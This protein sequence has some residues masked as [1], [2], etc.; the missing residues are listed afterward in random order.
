M[1]RTPTALTA[2]AVVLLAGCADETIAPDAAPPNQPPVL[3][4]GVSAQTL[5]HGEQRK[6]DLTG[7]FH[8]PD[9]DTLAY[10]AA[11][12]D[13]SVVFAGLLPGPVVGI[14]GLAQG[15]AAVTVVARDPEGLEARAVLPVSV[16]ENPDRAALVALYEATGGPDW[17]HNDNWLTDAPLWQWSGVD[18]D[19]TGRV[20]RL[21]LGSNNLTG[22]IPL[23][24]GNLAALEWLDLSEN[25]A[26][27][28][29][30]PPELGNLT[31]LEWLYLSNGLTG[32]IPPELGRLAALRVLRLSENNALTGPI[33]PELGDL[34]ALEWLDLSRT[35]LTGPIPPELGNLSA[36]ENLNLI[37]TGL[38]GP[39]PPE[40]GNLA[41]LE[42]LRLRDNEG[43]SGP[44]P[45]ELGNLA[46]LQELWLSSNGLTGPIPPELGNL[47]TLEA[48]HLDGNGLT[49]PIPPELGNLAALRVLH[50]RDNE[51]LSGPLPAT[52]TALE[53]LGGLFIDGTGLCIPG[54]REFLD[55]Q[56][57]IGTFF[58]GAFCNEAD[59]PVLEELYAAAGG[60]DWTRSDGWLGSSP[61][62]ADWHGVTTDSLGRVA[63][64]SL[65]ANNLAGGIAPVW[66][67]TELG[68]LD[69]GDNP[70]LQGRLPLVLTRL[71]LDTLRFSGTGLCSQLDARE[72]LE[73]ISVVEGTGETCE[74]LSDRDILVALYEATDGPNWSEGWP[75]GIPWLT[76]APLS[77]WHGVEVNDEGRVTGLGLHGLTG[78]I[79]PEL[80]GLA[81]LESLSLYSRTVLGPIPPELGRLSALRRLGIDGTGLTG[82]IPPELGDLAALEGLSLSGTGLTGLIPPELGN[83]AALERLDLSRTGLTG[84]IPPELGD[85]AALEGLYLVDT[86]LTGLIPPELGNLAALRGLYLNENDLTGPIPP[87]LGDL[88]G[89]V[90]LDLSYNEG[91]SGPLPATLT[92]MKWLRWFRASNT[93]LCTPADPEFQRW[94]EARSHWARRCEAA[95]AYLVQAAR[96]RGFPGPLVAGRE[97]LLRVFP[98]APS[99]RNR[100]PVPPVRAVFHAG[101]AEVYTVDIPGKPGPLPTEIEEG[102]LAISA[103]VKIPAHVLRPGLEMVV[104]IDPD[105]TLDPS[106]GVGGRIPEGGRL[107]LDVH[108]L[109]TM[110]LTVVP[111]LWT[112][113]PDS[114]IL[115]KVEGIAADPE[116]HELLRLPRALLPASDWSVTAH[117]PVWTDIQPSFANYYDLSSRMSAIRALENGRGYWMGTLTN[118]GGAAVRPG[119]TSVSALDGA[120]IA[121]ELGHNMSLGHAPC[122]RPT[123]SDGGFPDREGRIGAWGYDFTANKLMPPQTPDVMSYCR[124]AWISDY[125]FTKAL[126]H[127]LKAETESSRAPKTMALLLWGGDSEGNGPRLE[128]AFVVDAAPVLPDSAG[129]YTLT[130]RDAGGR[131]LFSL[132]FAMPEI[133][134]GGEAA[135]GFAYTLPVRPGWETLASVTLT[136]PDGRTATL[137]GSTD[138]PMS[139]RRDPRTGRVRAFLG[140]DV[141]AVQADGGNEGLA[142]ALGTMAVTSRGLPAPDAWRR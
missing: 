11:S 27:T 12:S 50:L 17:R 37:G 20:E 78:L 47:T 41:A 119:W 9:G 138:R 26:L 52:L 43:L 111:F 105:G 116:G 114:S 126:N 95:A 103:N 24:L 42:D 136:A 28:G 18:V 76:D 77:E 88:T 69:V 40:L 5:R 140:G 92:A 117:E 36:L 74:P 127:R 22:P 112:E 29:P 85:L 53:E 31:T 137:D 124:P 51:G 72:W 61:V 35:G 23:E 55:W 104:E 89:L 39:I 109:P 125:Y 91:L 19:S 135:G 100:V 110:K 16:T 56:E 25:N 21:Q 64:L 14:A 46:A 59:R 97:A 71:A 7:A 107:A 141:A 38:T 30:I 3:V 58:G 4:R 115:A 128:P 108:A 79:P 33:P 1:R 84:P 93:G 86:G 57:Q 8:D 48:L 98:M 122:G 68:S 90:E 70:R 94:L 101:G 81:A 60:P 120:T 123:F 80:V 65:P 2:A 87:E 134:D 32:P 96:R 102:S 44:I 121:H 83:L 113:N 49:G 142:A 133:A 63:G 82:P 132:A 45:P 131:E 99:G 106:L 54:T 66:A 10:T 130:G 13:S 73:S 67:L 6:I 15:E 129:G 75:R 34:A 139:I 62:L 118:W